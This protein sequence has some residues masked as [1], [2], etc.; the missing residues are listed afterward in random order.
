FAIT[1]LIDVL[2]LIVSAIARH[3]RWRRLLPASP[4]PRNAVLVGHERGSEGEEWLAALA[5]DECRRRLKV[6]PKQL[7][8]RSLDAVRVLAVRA[9][10][11]SENRS[12]FEAHFQRPAWE[13]LQACDP[14]IEDRIRRASGEMRRRPLFVTGRLIHIIT[15]GIGGMS[16]A[17]SW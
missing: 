1:L 15:L 5:Q 14:E 6:L 17:T 4:L 16:A 13:M 11:R 10:R 2:R 7:P 9:M 12:R 3:I 8:R